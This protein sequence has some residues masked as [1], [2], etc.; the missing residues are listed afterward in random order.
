K[1]CLHSSVA[2][3]RNSCRTTRRSLLIFGAVLCIVTLAFAVLPSAVF[4][5]DGNTIDTP[6]DNLDDWDTLNGDCSLPGGGS[7]SAGG[8]TA[9][10][11]IGSEDPPN[12]FTG[13]GS[14]DP[15]D[16]SSWKWKPADTVPDKDTITHAF[17]ASYN[18]TATGGDKV[19]VIGG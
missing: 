18:N 1:R 16:I 7:G 3:F 19:V 10:T 5:I 17:T 13:G 6:N 2:F 11:C 14:K 4:E 8:S 9:R 12:I 15:L